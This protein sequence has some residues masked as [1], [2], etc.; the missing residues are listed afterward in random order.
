MIIRIKIEGTMKGMMEG[1]RE[2]IIE[3]KIISWWVK[4]F[5]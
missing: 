4:M 3:E 2:E 1:M 5:N